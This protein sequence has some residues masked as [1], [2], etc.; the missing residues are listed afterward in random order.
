ML[1]DIV[2]DSLIFKYKSKLRTYPTERWINIESK[3]RI[4]KEIMT[5]K[6]GK[7]RTECNNRSIKTYLYASITVAV[8][9]YVIFLI[10]PDAY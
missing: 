4:M 7:E 10:I 2:L 5:E 9:K 3:S 8:S 1:L 6:N